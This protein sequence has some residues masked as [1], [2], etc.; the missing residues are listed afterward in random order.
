MPDPPPRQQGRQPPPR[1][2]R[3][4][5][6]TSGGSP[7]LSPAGDS[8]PRPPASPLAAWLDALDRGD[9]KALESAALAAQRATNDPKFADALISPRGPLY[10]TV[11][12]LPPSARDALS[13]RQAEIDAL[14]AN[15]PAPIPLG[16]VAQEGGVPKSVY[17][18]VGDVRIQIRGEYSRLGPVVPRHFPTIVAGEKQPPI[19]K[20]SGRLE[21]A[22]WLARPEHPLTARVMANRIWEFHFGEGIVRTPSN[23]GKLGE[24]PSDPD[25]LD[26]LSRRFIASGWSIKA[27]H[28]LVM[29][30]AAYQQSA[31]VPPESLKRDP[32]NRLFGRMNRR[33]LE[34]E[35]IRD[36][37]L[38]VA[39]RLDPTMGGPSYRDFNVPRRT[40]YLMTIRS[41]R[42][43]FGPLFDAA[44]A[45][46]MVDKRVVSTV[47]PQALFLLNNQFVMDQAKA[48]A[49]RVRREATTTAARIDRAYRLAYG[50]A[51]KA[52]E[53]GVGRQVVGAS[54]DPAVWAAY[55]HVLLCGNEFL[56]VD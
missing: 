49:D 25:L 15:P 43:S 46:A 48:F 24:P 27:M 54:D 42:S 16:L 41:D 37:L 45:T 2:A 10:P 35:P 3:A 18:K 31:S 39:G 1:P 30:S 29:N 32:E 13:R 38:S 51:A 23:F 50:R 53:I 44:D 21:L 36:S 22:R 33:R 12:E 28:R 56:F 47:A 5:S 6:R 14:R 11:A 4:P 19:A 8:P 17:E 9:T 40:L 52:E 26:H 55:A 20:G 7:R 34:S